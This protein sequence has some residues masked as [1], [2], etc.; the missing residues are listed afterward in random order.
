MKIVYKGDVP[1]NVSNKRNK[2]NTGSD[3]ITEAHTN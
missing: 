3:E 2:R 1:P